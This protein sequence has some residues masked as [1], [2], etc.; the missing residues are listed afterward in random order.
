MYKKIII[1]AVS[2]I[3]IGS[4][5]SCTKKAPVPVDTGRPDPV[6]QKIEKN[7]AEIHKQLIKL[8]RANQQKVKD[9]WGEVEVVKVPDSGPLSRPVTFRWSGPL[10]DAIE[11]L[12][13]MIAYDFKVVGKKPIRD[14]L[15]SIDALDQPVFS[16]LEDLGWQAG[17]NIGVVVDQDLMIIKIAYAGGHN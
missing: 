8:S 9:T 12:A 16:I 7:S 6:L 14:R 13:G 17:E 2:V 1:G 3:L 10:S 15:V 11:T 5:P 4:L